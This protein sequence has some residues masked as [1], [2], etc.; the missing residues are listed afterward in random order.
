MTSTTTSVSDSIYTTLNHNSQSIPT[1]VKVTSPSL[2]DNNADGDIS[3]ALSKV[4][5]SSN[6]VT[7]L[8]SMQ[9]DDAHHLLTSHIKDKGRVPI[10]LLTCNRPE[11]LEKTLGNDI[12][13]IN[14][15]VI[16]II[17]TITR[18]VVKCKKREEK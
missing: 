2:I 13:I 14:I 16:I 5:L 15:I 7:A 10:V 6:V 3:S 4:W 12:T 9:G 18:I 1:M 17:S 8:N 11:F